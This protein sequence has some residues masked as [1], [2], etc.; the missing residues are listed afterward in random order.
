L[1]EGL[2]VQGVQDSSAPRFVQEDASEWSEAKLHSQLQ[3]EAARPFDLSV[4]PGWRVKLFRCSADRNVLALTAHHILADLWSLT[5][6]LEELTEAYVAELFDSSPNLPALE[7][8]YGDFVRGQS[9]WL[10]S[11]EGRQAGERCL[12]RLTGDWPTLHLPTTAMRVSEPQLSGAR[13][14]LRLGGACRDRVRRFS[15]THQVTPYVTL[16]SVFQLLLSR[17]TAQ[18]KFLIGSPS[19]GRSQAEFSR[20]IGYFVN[21]IVLRVDLEGAPSFLQLLRETRV[22]VSDALADEAFPFSLLVGR[23][24]PDR[25]PQRAPLFNLLWGYPEAG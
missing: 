7:A 16:L 3:Q 8:T 11:P 25:N 23:L 24:R 17:Y 12:A 2:P 14:T 13:R 22:E 9:A 10:A 18:R 5:V 20:L 19:A 6:W 21:P 15:Q 1:R 4:A